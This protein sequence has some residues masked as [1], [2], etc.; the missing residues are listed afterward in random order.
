[1]NEVT[2]SLVAESLRDLGVAP[3][4]GVLVHAAIQYLGR[5]AEGVGLYGDA[6]RDVLGEAGT[7]AVP[8]FNFGFARGAT[9]DR[10]TTPCE[11]M[12]VFAEYVRTLPEARRTTHPLQ[13]VA[14]VGRHADDLAGR[15]TP[16]AF[17][18]GSAFGRMLEL[19]FK[20]VLLGA[21]IQ[22]ASIVHYS[23][24]KQRV[25][26]RYWKDFRGT[27]I[28][29]GQTREAVY[30]MYARDLEL[31]PRMDFLPV[32]KRLEAEGRWAARKLNYGTV[33]ACALTDVVAAADALLQEDP[34]ALV[35]NREE[36]RVRTKA[37]RKDEAPG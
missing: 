6:F 30:R 7:V 31:D 19:G 16:G 24:Q 36:L 1:V 11:K 21:S 18:E 29:S 28:D 15:D 27:V 22:V 25:P 12:G 3:G 2:R 32:Q 9:F 20:M 33:A 34:W 17:D 14:A 23:E 10:R 37:R 4:Q 26:Y 35:G 8:T 13:S 5:P